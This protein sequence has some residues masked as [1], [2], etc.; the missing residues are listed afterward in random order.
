MQCEH[1][2][3]LFFFPFILLFL[4]QVYTTTLYSQKGKLQHT[5]QL[6]DLH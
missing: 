2:F 4:N 1:V 6:K 5:C 3:Y